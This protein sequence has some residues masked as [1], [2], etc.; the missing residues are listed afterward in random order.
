MDLI[1]KSC[2]LIFLAEISGKSVVLLL[3]SWHFRLPTSFWDVRLFSTYRHPS[4]DILA[5]TFQ[6]VFPCRRTF[7]SST[8]R[9]ASEISASR[10]P[11]E[12]LPTSYYK[13]CEKNIYPGVQYVRVWVNLE[14]SFWYFRLPTSFWD[15]HLPTSFREPPEIFLK[16][17]QK[18]IYPSIQSVRVFGRNLKFQ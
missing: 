13:K 16:N 7:E 18:N 10:R 14:N 8:Y 1:E 5:T 15:F 11:S 17:M 3:L 12:D 6:F 2:L 4:E 9:C